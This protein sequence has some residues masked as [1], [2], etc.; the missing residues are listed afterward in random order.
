MSKKLRIGT[1]DSQLALW[2]ANHVKSLLKKHSVEA[3]LVLIKSEGDLDLI[4][5]L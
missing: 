1:R 3:E 2:Q 4:T 5:P